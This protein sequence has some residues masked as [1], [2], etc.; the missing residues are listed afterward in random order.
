[1]AY[2]QPGTT[3]RWKLTA[4][5]YTSSA[6]RCLTQA[7]CIEQTAVYGFADDPGDTPPDQ[8]APPGGVFLIARDTAGGHALACGGWRSA[9]PCSAEIK[10]MYTVP[11]ARGQGIG[12]FLL[13]A[14]EQNAGNHGRYRVILETG[15]RNHAALRLYEACGYSAIPSYAA[16][17]DPAVNRAMAKVLRR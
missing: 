6:A 1:M 15:Y 12:R 2:P 10:R 16:G 4:V 3:P 13:R 9:G 7:L 8:F 17:R 5:S 14:L 11:G